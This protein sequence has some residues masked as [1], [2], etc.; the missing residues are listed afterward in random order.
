IIGRIAAHRAKTPVILHTL[1]LLSWQDANPLVSAPHHKLMSKAKEWFYFQLERYCASL[2][3]AIVTVSENNKKEAIAQKLA[4]AEKFTHIYSGIE[5][6]KFQVD[7]SREEKCR[8][9]GL[10]ATQP[11]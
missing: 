1:H 8:S 3:D 10:D 2:S 5:M 7:I 9:L 4:P 11:I 6:H